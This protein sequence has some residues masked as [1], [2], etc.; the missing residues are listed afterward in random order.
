MREHSMYIETSILHIQVQS[1]NLPGRNF[2]IRVLERG[3]TWSYRPK[4]YAQAAAAINIDHHSPSR[5]TRSNGS[6]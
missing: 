5:I 6:I 2:H 4:A 3:G 1:R